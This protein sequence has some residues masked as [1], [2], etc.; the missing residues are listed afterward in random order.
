MVTKSGLRKCEEKQFLFKLIQICNICRSVCFKQFHCAHAHLF[1]S[2]HPIEMP[3]EK[4]TK[5]G[6]VRPLL[7]IL[8]FLEGNSIHLSRELMVIHVSYSPKVNAPDSPVRIH[9][10]SIRIWIQWLGSGVSS[11]FSDPDPVI[12][13]RI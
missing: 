4:Q 9:N 2:Y 8:G 1:L 13:V 7:K 11:F 3:C 10:L 5:R 12:F 6:N